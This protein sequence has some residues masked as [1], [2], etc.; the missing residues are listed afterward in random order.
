MAYISRRSVLRG[1]AAIGFTSAT[2]L[3]SVMG[4]E[5]FAADTSGYKALV[6]VF[7]KGGMDTMDAILP[8]DAES[9]DAFDSF[10]SDIN[11]GQSNRSRENI[12][13]IESSRNFGGRRFGFAPELSDLRDLYNAGSLAI[14]GNTGP[15]IEPINRAGMDNRVPRPRQLFS[16]NDQQSMWMSFGLEGERIG[17]GGEFADRTAAASGD[18]LT[19][20]SITAAAPEPFLTGSRTRQYPARKSGGVPLRLLIDK[21]R[22]GRNADRARQVLAD[23][24]ASR[25][26][27]SDNPYVRDLIAGNTRNLDDN[28]SF[29]A[30]LSM[31]GNLSTVFPDNYLGRQLETVA[32]TIAVRSTLGVSRQ[33]FY[34]EMLGLDT[35]ATQAALLPGRQ[36]ELNGAVAAFNAAMREIGMDDQV[37]L[38]TASDFGRTLLVNGD[39]TDHGWGGHYFVVGG[40]VRGGDIYGDIPPIDLTDSQYTESRGRLIPT[41]SVDQYAASLGKWFGL[42]NG[43]LRNALPNLGNFDTVPNLF[44]AGNTL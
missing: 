29:A 8:K 2:G 7:M 42:T 28:A 15:L 31:A 34:T 13:G 33:V 24:Y 11:S 4:Q 18:A 19:F 38:F 43:E 17:W 30:A 14:M 37:T 23:H 41:T 5:A 36:A 10:R 12:L 16:H 21:S 6:C 27:T 25:A 32:T 35:H 44:G 20:A 1:S 3:L 26:R 39:G 22:L 9:Y 40:A